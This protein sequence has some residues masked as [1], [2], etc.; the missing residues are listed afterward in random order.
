MAKKP[1]IPVTPGSGNVF[2]DISVPEPD[3]EL[4]KAQLASRIREIVRGRRL[5][6]VSAAAVMGIDQPKVSA[7]LSGRLQNISSERLMRL[8]TWLGQ[9]VEIVVKSKPRRRQH[10]RIRVVEEARA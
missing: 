4:A 7:L 6:Q 1:L 9:D 3:E 5:T 8:L 2:A 10:G